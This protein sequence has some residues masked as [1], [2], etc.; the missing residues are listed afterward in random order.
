MRFHVEYDDTGGTFSCGWCVTAPRTFSGV[1]VSID[2]VQEIE[3]ALRDERDEKSRLHHA[4]MYLSMNLG[5]PAVQV[6]PDIETGLMKFALARIEELSNE[7]SKLRSMC[8]GL[9]R[10]HA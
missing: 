9:R 7:V 5:N 10:P 8:D 1:V 3:D 4:V 6:D 2:E